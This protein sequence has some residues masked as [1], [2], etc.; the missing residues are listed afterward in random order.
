MQSNY[1]LFIDESKSCEEVE[2]RLRNVGLS[3]IRVQEC[4]GILPRLSGPEGVFNGT[5][6]ILS[7]FTSR[8]NDP[9]PNRD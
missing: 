3:F 7:Y 6:S 2:K 8:S 9:V 5:S 4:G 1:Y